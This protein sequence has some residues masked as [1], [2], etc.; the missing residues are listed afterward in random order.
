MERIEF[1]VNNVALSTSDNKP[2]VRFYGRNEEGEKFCAV[3]DSVQDYFWILEGD[4]TSLEGFEMETPQGLCRVEKVEVKKKLLKGDEVSA[5]KV[6]VNNPLLTKYLVSALKKKDDYSGFYEHDIPFIQKYLID[7]GIKSFHSVSV[8][9][10]EVPKAG[11][12]VDK[13]IRIKTVESTNQKSFQPIVLSFDI[14]TYNP[15]KEFFVHGNEIIAVSLKSNKGVSK[16][17][18]WKKFEGGRDVEF[19]KDEAELLK[20]FFQTVK[21]ADPDIIV[22]Y[23]SDSFDFPSILNRAEKLGVKSAVGWSGN[24]PRTVRSSSGAAVW[25]D[26]IAHLDIYAFFA[27]VMHDRLKTDVLSLDRV[28]KELLEEEKKDLDYEKIQKLWESNNP[29]D[30]CEYC[31]VDSELTLK[32]F[33]KIF[34]LLNEIS[35]ITFKQAFHACRST[36]GK[37]VESYLLKESKS[38]GELRLNKPSIKQAVQRRRRT[39]EGGYV[40]EPKPGLYENLAVFDFRSLY[41][42]IIISHNISPSSL[43]KGEPEEGHKVPGEECWFAKKPVGV[44]SRVL[45]ELIDRRVGVKRIIKDVDPSSTQHA[46]LDARQYALKVIANSFY[47]YLGF[48]R[49]RWYSLPCA[50]AVTSYGR[51]YIQDIIKKAKEEDFKVIYADTDSVFLYKKKSF[52]KS[53]KK[54]YQEFLDEINEE[55]PGVM[56]MDFEGLFK[57]GLF[58]SKKSGGRGAKKKYALLDE[59]DELVIKGF[60][61]VRRDWSPLAKKLQLK[62][63]KKVLTNKSVEDAVKIVKQKVREL[64]EGNT[65]LKELIISVQLK[66][67]LDDYESIGPHV[68]AALKAKN[69]G[70]FV[71]KGMLIKY[72]VT[73]GEGSISDR[74][75]IY[76]QAKKEGLKYDSKYYIYKQ[77][78]PSV[79]RILNA[80][81]VEEKDYLPRKEKGQEELT[82]F[83]K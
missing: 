62:V 48:P 11:F 54:T 32:L 46:I 51:H 1:F 41:P 2:E 18:T 82:K 68:S 74:S 64:V 60:E 67:S 8:T 66:K 28:S 76:E 12:K 57:R 9:G 31:L 42:S 37:L 6:W 50:N 65:P 27:R 71:R 45:K 43:M 55:L 26:G 80:L 59:N 23:N 19:V 17:I 14:E 7:R 10:K 38:M 34:P 69:E 73:E 70:Y 16:V 72:V 3:D 22:G 52:F 75:F 53:A 47:G 24:K 49:S 15:R 33:Q 4:P 56:K 81:S 40:H 58:I 78:L 83:L 13:K 44:I 35:K 77:V 25:V 30:I 5:T 29:K 36:Y 39:F 63:L 79:K 20:K 61:Y 21:E